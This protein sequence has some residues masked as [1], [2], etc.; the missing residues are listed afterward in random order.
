MIHTILQCLSAKTTAWNEF[1]S[2]M[3]SAII[4]LADNQKFNFSKYIFDN[5]VKS[6]EGG[7]KFYLFLR[8]LRIGAGF[9]R[10]I[11]PLFDTM[12]KL[13]KPK[14]KQR[15]EADTSH[16]ASADKDHVPTPSSDPLPSE[17][18]AAQVKEIVALKKKVS[19]V[20]K[21][22][23][24]RS[25]GLRRLKKFGSIR[26]VK[27]PMEKDGLG[28]QEDASKQRKMIKEI[29]QNAE[30]ALDDETRG[31]T[32]DDEMFGVDDLAGEEVVMETTT[33]IKDSAASITDV[34]ED[35]IT[36][37]QALAAL[38][39]VKPK[40]VVQEKEMSTT[41]PVAAT[42]VTTVIPTPRSKENGN[43]FKPVAETT[44][45]DAGTSTTII[46]SPV[47][48]EN[49]AKKK[50]DIKARIWRNKSDLDTMSLDD[51]YNNFK[52]VEQEVKGTTNT[53]TSSQNMAFVSSPSPNSTSKVPTIFGVSTTS[54]QVKENQEKD[55]IRSKSDKNKKRGEAGKSLKQLQWVEEEKLSKTQKEWPKTQT[56]S[57]AIQ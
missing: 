5:L 7:V 3:T 45:N 55:K 23:K 13:Q 49:K 56:Q 22:R 34:T 48:N 42:K 36:M 57:K 14:R 16:D 52:I 18:K 25:E 37:A 2:T 32:N 6:L 1:S 8:F 40:V 11:T 9:S 4:C 47:T 20:N 12:M 31:R 30:I 33:G 15:K 21:W 38:K 26:K 27:S 39:S 43:S 35:E 53:N 41:I 24:S 10:V 29:D 19:K 51:L 54:P 44:T 17:A 46:P 28:A 50:N